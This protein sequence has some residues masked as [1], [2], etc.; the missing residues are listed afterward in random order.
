MNFEIGFTTLE[1]DNINSILGKRGLLENGRVQKVIDSSCI[2]YSDP[3]TPMDSGQLIGS[4]NTH[5]KI[6]SGELI[7]GVPYAH[8]QNT[9]ISA[10]GMPLNYQG[11]PM[12][13]ANWFERMKRDHYQDIVNNAQKELER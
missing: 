13:G 4:V 1:L 11:S 8:Y 12:R 3:Y 9:G 10:N 7:W 2:S 5:S 6:G